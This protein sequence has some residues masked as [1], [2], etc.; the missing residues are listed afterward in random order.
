MGWEVVSKSQYVAQAGL[1]LG[2]SS[3]VGRILKLIILPCFPEYWDYK[4]VP[5]SNP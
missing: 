3:Q 2:C 4:H 1:E 5:K